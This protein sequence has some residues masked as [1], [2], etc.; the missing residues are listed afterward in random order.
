[1]TLS[2]FPEVQEEINNSDALKN[3]LAS[4]WL[5]RLKPFIN[6]Q[7]FTNILNTLKEDKAKGI[8]VYPATK[9]VFKAF[10]LCGFD[11]LKVILAAQD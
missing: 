1:M 7:K 8:K 5:E 6:S 2:L 9:D 10:N 3:I 4:D 11:E